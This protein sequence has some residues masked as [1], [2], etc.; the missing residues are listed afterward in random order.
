[1]T[2]E[3][4]V[5]RDGRVTDVKVIKSQPPFDTPA[6]SSVKKMRFN[7]VVWRGHRVEWKHKVTVRFEFAAGTGSPTLEPAPGTEQRDTAR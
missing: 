1:M 7:P 6:L 5:D 2:L 3:I 4:I